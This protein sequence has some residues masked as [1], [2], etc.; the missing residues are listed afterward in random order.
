VFSPNECNER[1]LRGIPFPSCVPS[2]RSILCIWPA[3][4]WP[5]WLWGIKLSLISRHDGGEDKTWLASCNASL[6]R[7]QCSAL[8]SCS[9]DYFAMLSVQAYKAGHALLTR[10]TCSSSRRNGIGRIVVEALSL[11]RQK[12]IFW[13]RSPDIPSWT[14]FP[15][16]HTGASSRN[17]R[18]VHRLHA[19]LSN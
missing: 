17:A 7:P 16:L 3:L 15:V 4:S 12:G 6:L 9:R 13:Q 2:A 5:A 19:V 8:V 1:G 11:P 18:G 14:C 10:W